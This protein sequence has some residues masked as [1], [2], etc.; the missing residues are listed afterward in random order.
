MSSSAEM[1]WQLLY[2][3]AHAEEWVEVNLR[4]QGYTTLLPRV[5][6]RSGYRPLFPR[7]IFAGFEADR[8]VRELRSTRGVSYVVQCGEVPARVPVEVIAEIEG[9]MDPWGVVAVDVKPAPGSLF[10]KAERERVRALVRFAEAGWRVR[11]A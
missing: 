5:Q 11:V 8:S 9:R 6:A 4:R 1:C 3:K 10:G 2:T 7:Y